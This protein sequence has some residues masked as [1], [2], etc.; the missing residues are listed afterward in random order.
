MS[1]FKIAVIQGDG[2]GPAR[3]FLK[4][5]QHS[6]LCTSSAWLPTLTFSMCLLG[7]RNIWRREFDISNEM[8][9]TC[10]QADVIL[11]GPV[12]LPDVRYDDG[13]E[14]GI[15]I[16]LMLRFQLD[17][18]AEHPASLPPRRCSKCLEK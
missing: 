9:E 11:K 7:P 6:E 3:L 2:V 13:T 1:K 16:E 8:L 15:H 18:F 4:P 10:K 12:G 17:L 5:C 14:V